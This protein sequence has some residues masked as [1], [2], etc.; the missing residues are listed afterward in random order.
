MSY[1]RN[2][3]TT[4][5]DSFSIDAFGRNRVSNPVTLFASQHIYDESPDFWESV[6][7][8][9]GTAA[10]VANE[11]CVRIT[12]TTASGDKVVRQ[13]RRYFRY[14]PG[15]SQLVFLTGVFGASK[16][17]VRKRY[18]YFDASNGIFA[19]Q[20]SAGMSWVRRTN[21]T[22]SPVDTSVA[23]T[24]WNIDKL[25]GTGVSGYTIDMSKAQ[26]LAID[27]EWLGV[28]RVRC[29][30]V[31]DGKILYCHQFLN[32]NNLSTVYMSTGSLPVRAEIENTAGTASGTSMDVICS[33]VI[34]EGGND[35]EL[36][37]RVRSA[38]NGTSTISVSTRRAILTIRPK[39]TLNSIT[40]RGL[41]NLIDATVHN[42]GNQNIL[43]ELVKGHSLGGSPSYTSVSATSLVEYDVTGTTITG[44][45][46]IWSG[47][48]YQ[49]N[50]GARV[51][52]PLDHL[53]NSDIPLTLSVAGTSP[54]LLSIV[55]T[56]LGTATACASA[57]TWR[58]IY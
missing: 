22:G 49:S 21:V 35:A 36:T 9:G 37:S 3:N 52:M 28:G 42:T 15:K 12:N 50:A 45:E 39:A 56:S 23:Q 20:T 2:V 4:S 55:I 34:S 13:T 30:F 27:M 44:G 7:T 57:M 19:E 5:A 26:I 47:Y 1:L 17:N 38:N 33:T 46:T 43:I 14:T 32:A 8:G 48:G 40:N 24:N 53:V 18:G 51:E 16:A 58:E 11:S 25:D 6:L 10:H 29:G 54:T 41:I 31:I